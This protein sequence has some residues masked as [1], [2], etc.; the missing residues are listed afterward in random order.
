[1]KM[2][3]QLLML[4]SAEGEILKL[5]NYSAFYMREWEKESEI[6]GNP[7]LWQVFL[8]NTLWKQ[9]RPWKFELKF[10]HI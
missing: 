8:S 7:I 9:V 4:R 6:E 5:C 1:M 10:Y 2:G 3:Q